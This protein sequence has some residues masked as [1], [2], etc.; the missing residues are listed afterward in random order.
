MS[1]SSE[2]VDEDSEAAGRKFWPHA[3]TSPE[4][5]APPKRRGRPPGSKTKRPA[6]AVPTEPQLRAAPLTTLPDER[7][8]SDPHAC[9]GLEALNAGL[10]D[11]LGRLDS[12]AMG[13]RPRTLLVLVQDRS[14]SEREHEPE[15]REKSR[16]IPEEFRKSPVAGSLVD[17]AHCAGDE[18]FELLSLTHAK[19]FEFPPAIRYGRGTHAIPWLAGVRAVVDAYRAHQTAQGVG[20]QDVVVLW[21]T[22]YAFADDFRPAVAE[23]AVWARAEKVTVVPTGFGQW[24]RLVASEFSQTV[25]PVDL[26]EVPL[27]KLFRIVSQTVVQA[28][29]R[30]PGRVRVADELNRAFNGRSP[31]GTN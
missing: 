26:Q 8:A 5:A 14:P 21:A 23:F 25:E 28:S 31:A 11:A 27:A 1:R 29:Q 30:G 15:W 19:D 13:T 24:S 4:D 7:P 2:R 12:R 16:V 18:G 3:P 6:P 22:D 20:V 17:V 9:A 10:T